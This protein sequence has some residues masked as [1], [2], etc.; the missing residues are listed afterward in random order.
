MDPSRY[1]YKVPAIAKAL[2]KPDGRGAPGNAIRGWCRRGFIEGFRQAKPGA[3]I[4]LNAHG[5]R[6]AWLNWADHKGLDPE[7]DMPKLISSIVT[8]IDHPQPAST[9]GSSPAVTIEVSPGV[10]V[11]VIYKSE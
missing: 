4:Y 5:V 8:A 2:P 1:A 11:E 10:K 9:R 6:E 7:A 3:Q